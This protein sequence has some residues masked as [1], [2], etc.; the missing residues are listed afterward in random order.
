VKGKNVD[1][2]FPVN[3]S[4]AAVDTLC[5]VAVV[6]VIPADSSPQDRPLRFSA[7]KVMGTDEYV[8]E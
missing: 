5:P 4:F 2:F 8:V 7:S 1:A 3:V 6:S